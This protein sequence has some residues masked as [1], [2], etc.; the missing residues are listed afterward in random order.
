MIFKS[1]FSV[2]PI[3]LVSA[4]PIVKRRSKYSVKIS[5]KKKIVEKKRIFMSSNFEDCNELIFSLI[6]FNF[7]VIMA[8][9]KKW[10]DL[11]GFRKNND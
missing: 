7:S 3:G 5:S 10:K 11:S 6:P 4:L 8:V 1:L 9:I 2:F